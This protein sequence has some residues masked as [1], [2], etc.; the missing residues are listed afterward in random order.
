MKE[1]EK[2]Q[3]IVFGGCFNPPLNS[4]FSLAEQMVAEYPEIEKIVFVPVNSQYE[5]MD[6]IENEHRYQMLKAVCEKNEKFEVSRIEIDSKRQLY[7]VETLY[8]LQEEYKDYEVAFLTG[9]DNLKTLDIWNKAD[10]LTKKFK[11]YIL[12][13]DKDNMEEI[14][15]NNAF[16]RNHRQAFIKANHRQAFIKAK[17][18]IKSNLS[19]TFVREKIKNRK[20]IRYLTPDEVIAYI[21][22]Q[23]LYR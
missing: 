10:E 9:S 1:E 7:T 5:K 18:T 16:L 13:R 6:L 17:D 2:K 14:I 22:E 11:I 3:I 12:E 8:K 20:S 21:E 19:S 15:Q 23:K 4:H